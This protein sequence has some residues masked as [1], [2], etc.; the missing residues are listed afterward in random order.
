MEYCFLE[1]VTNLTMYELYALPPAN[2]NLL[3]N[4]ALCPV[5][6]M[7]SG[8]HHANG[9][10]Y[11]QLFAVNCKLFPE[12]LRLFKCIVTASLATA[13]WCSRA[14]PDNKGVRQLGV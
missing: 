4:A 11:W 10:C 3:V 12:L 2:T 1:T 6:T 9:I 8:I 14:I 13:C 5:D 7:T